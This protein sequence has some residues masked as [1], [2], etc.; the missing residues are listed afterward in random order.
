[1]KLMTP[2]YVVRVWTIALIAIVPCLSSRSAAQAPPAFTPSVNPV[3]DAVRA[4]V[5]RESKNLIESAEL[6]PAEKYAF[7]P[8]PAQMTFGKLVAH[9]VQTNVFI[10]SGIGST[11]P[12]M[13]PEELKK[14]SGT[15]AKDALVAAMKKSFDYCSDSL[16]KVQ[17]STLGEEVSMFGRKAGQSRG[18]AMVTIATDWT[19]HYSTAA[20]YLRLNGILPPTAQPKK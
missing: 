20:S 6:M 15:E 17:D 9:V 19:D 8:T 2:A 3:S 16:A 7:Q 11:P 12:P 18:A 4:L 14:L 1:M 5:A 10:C 13:T